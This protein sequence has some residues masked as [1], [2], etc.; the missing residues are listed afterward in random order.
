[1]G[2]TIR[3]AT[4]ADAALVH[5]LIVELAVYERE[6]DAVEATPASLEA[7]LRAEVPPFRC[8]VLE[9]EGEGV[10]FALYFPTYSTWR[11]LPGIHLEDL[12]VRPAF[13]GRGHGKALLAELARRTEA[14]GG[15]R[16]EWAV[17]DWNQPAI[18]FYEALGAVAQDQWRTF[19]LDGE[20][21]ARLR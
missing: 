2:R 16:L 9:D 17:L 20:A 10:G 7:Q 1:M 6:P 5:A 19:R 13:R 12:Y 14:L 8:L 18:D 21:L 11:G 15:G 4:P 3:D